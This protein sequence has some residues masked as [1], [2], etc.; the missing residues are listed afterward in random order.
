M[1]SY[2]PN[3][4]ILENRLRTRGRVLDILLRDRT[5][6]RNIIWATDSYAGRGREF[7]SKRQIK[8]ELVTGANG[9]L[10]QPRASKSKEEQRSRT[11]DKAEVFTPLKI[12]GEMNKAVDWASKNWPVGDDN[13]QDYV[14]ELRLE[15]TCGEAPF[16]AGRYNPTSD[17]GAIIK[18]HNRVGFLD[19][20]L[21]IVAKFTTSK[22]EW[23]HW[24]EAALKSSYGYEWQGD[25]LL[26]ARE[27]ILQTMDD[28]Y[29]DKFGGERGLSTEQ[30]E[31]FAEIISWNIWQMD[32]IK[33]VV[34][35]S[36]KAT[37]QKDVIDKNQMALFAP[38]K[39]KKVIIEC[40]GCRTNDHTQH[41]GRYSKIMD[42]RKG[43]T[44]RFI[45][46]V[47]GNS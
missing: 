6:G 30:L 32:G 43:K 29:R 38:E 41:T 18:P 21:Q 37:V 42:W 47:N 25:N 5:T 3:I 31:H 20:K 26:I 33:C 35:M 19:R 23:L 1:K 17:T 39:P 10:I 2:T 15:I 28:F 12:V 36:C 4:D 8:P 46:V 11:K 34:P 27:N 14:G 22:K 7:D 44:I 16:I 9:K 13:W 24:A 45:D 40:P